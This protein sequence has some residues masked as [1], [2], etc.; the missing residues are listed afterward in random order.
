MKEHAPFL[1]KQ[2]LKGFSNIY[3]LFTEVL[4]GFKGTILSGVIMNKYLNYDMTEEVY[5]CIW[6]RK[7]SHIR[8]RNLENKLRENRSFE[9]TLFAQLKKWAEAELSP[10]EIKEHEFEGKVIYTEDIRRR[11]VS[12]HRGILEYVYKDILCLAAFKYTL[13]ELVNLAM[14]GDDS[15]LFKLV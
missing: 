14:N 8:L 3:K 12:Q 9:N 6:Q 1:Q 13:E 15:S 5:S 2:A 11:K 10:P 4:P 7:D